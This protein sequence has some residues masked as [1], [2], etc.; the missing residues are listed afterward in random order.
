MV[1]QSDAI[2]NPGTVMVETLDTVPA[3]GAMPASH[4]PNRLTIWAEQVRLDLPEHGSEIY[5][6]ILDV[7]W[8]SARYIEQ[9]KVTQND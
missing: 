4:C 9:E 5:F 6:V 2:V 3:D 8:I 7:A 1:I